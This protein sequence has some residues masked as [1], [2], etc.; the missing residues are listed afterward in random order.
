MAMCMLLALSAILLTGAVL[1]KGWHFCG[2]AYCACTPITK[3]SR[4]RRVRSCNHFGNRSGK[5]SIV[6]ST[7][8]RP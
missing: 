5:I 7:T 3:F 6:D 2:N 1:H 4:G 8:A